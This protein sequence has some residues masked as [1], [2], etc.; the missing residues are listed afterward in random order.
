[1]DKLVA[2]LVTFAV[3]L[4]VCSVCVLGPSAVGAMLIGVVAWLG[5]AGAVLSIGLAIMLGFLVYRS[6]R[7]SRA[8]PDDR[9]P[10]SRAK[11]ISRHKPDAHGA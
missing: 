6:M 9:A 5:G 8:R 1:M 3:V 2:G 10:D 7:R 11:P 4:P